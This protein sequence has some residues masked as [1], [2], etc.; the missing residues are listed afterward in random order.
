VCVCCR[1]P[2]SIPYTTPLYHI[3]PPLY[4]SPPLCTILNPLYTIYLS[5]VL[6]GD[7]LHMATPRTGAGAYSAMIDA[8][9]L[10]EA[11]EGGQGQ[12]AQGAQGTH[13]LD[14]ALE[15]YGRQAVARSD[16]LHRS[17]RSHAGYFA[18]DPS[19]T[20]SPAVFAFDQGIY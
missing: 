2:I 7:A 14:E 10:G 9:A 19:T 4:H 12:G 6:L 20:I 1:P 5:V 3:K 18:P 16:D 8:V 15:V 11:L 17:S 13:G